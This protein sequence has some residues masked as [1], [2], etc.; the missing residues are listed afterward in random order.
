M[1]DEMASYAFERAD[2]ADDRHDDAAGVLL[3]PPLRLPRDLEPPRLQRPGDE[4]HR[5]TST[6]TRPARRAGG[7]ASP[8]RRS[9]P[10]RASSSKSAATCCAASAAARAHAARAPVAEAQDDRLGRLAHQ[11]HRPVRRLHPAGGAALREGEPAVLQPDAHARPAHREGRRARRRSAQRM[12]DHPGD[13]QGAAGARQGA[14]HQTVGAQERRGR[15]A[16]EPVGV[17]HQERRPRRRCQADRRDHPRQRHPRHH[18]APT[19]RWRPCARTA[20]C[21]PSA[22]ATRR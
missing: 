5:S 21:A 1:T 2:H 20:R 13:R 17:D 3:V 12:A 16:G 9:R 11:H 7:P 10:S 18:S 8:S 22:G 4:A 19:R 15:A 14:R 6:S